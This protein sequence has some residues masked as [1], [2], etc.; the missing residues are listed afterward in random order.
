MRNLYATFTGNQGDFDSDVLRFVYGSLTTPPTTTDYDMITGR[1][2]H[3]HPVCLRASLH[4][5]LYCGT[6]RF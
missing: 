6:L 1:R 3:V 5:S 4:A 2:C